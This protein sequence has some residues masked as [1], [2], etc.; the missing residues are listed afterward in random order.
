MP[1]P[2]GVKQKCSCPVSAPPFPECCLS[3]GKLFEK[4]LVAKP[5]PTSNRFPNRNS[6]SDEVPPPGGVGMH[7]SERSEGGGEA[8]SNLD[9]NLD[10]GPTSTSISIQPELL[11]ANPG[12]A[13]KTAIK[14]ARS[15]LRAQTAYHVPT[16]LR[17]IL[18][19]INDPKTPAKIKA[20]LSVW[21]CEYSGGK[22]SVQK[23]DASDTGQ[24]EQKNAEVTDAE[25]EEVLQSK[26]EEDNGD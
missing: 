12:N 14:A 5:F 6:N 26:P 7:T 20:D 18:G 10:P 19:L 15:F 3:S 17:T 24:Q 8:I 1:K 21:I 4:D 25:L 9:P 11:M 2:K 13:S 22:P 16:A 23:D